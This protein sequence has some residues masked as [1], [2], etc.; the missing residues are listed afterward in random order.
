MKFELSNLNSTEQKPAFGAWAPG[1]YMFDCSKCGTRSMGH[2]RAS[3]CS[4]CAYDLRGKLLGY[5]QNCASTAAYCKLPHSD[6]WYCPDCVAT[7]PHIVHGEAKQQYDLD[8]KTILK[9]LFT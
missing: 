6:V 7:V 4:K 2:K 1:W 9:D 5:C 3:V 8:R